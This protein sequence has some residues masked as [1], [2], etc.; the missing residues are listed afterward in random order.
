[1]SQQALCFSSIQSLEEEGKESAA[2]LL[3]LAQVHA[4]P[5]ARA[6]IFFFEYSTDIEVVPA[7][8]IWRVLMLFAHLHKRH[9]HR[10]QTRQH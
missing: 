6:A 4:S 9:K 8:L 10:G 7:G 1:M 2:S 3:F 5:L